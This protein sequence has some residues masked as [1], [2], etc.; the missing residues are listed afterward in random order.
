MPG[1][2]FERHSLELCDDFRDPP[3][4]NIVLDNVRPELIDK[5]RPIT[6]YNTHTTNK[7]KKPI[8]AICSR[9]FT[10]NYRSKPSNAPLR[11]FL[12]VT[13]EIYPKR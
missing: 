3:V 10:I 1:S 4:R 11:H 5:P 8:T 7:K 13:T 2:L 9:F 12:F 6:F